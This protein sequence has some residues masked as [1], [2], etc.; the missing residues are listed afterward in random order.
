[1]KLHVPVNQENF[2]FKTSD[3]VANEIVR[4]SE[5]VKKK[6]KSSTLV[7]PFI[8]DLHLGLM[9][10]NLKNLKK[11]SYEHV[12]NLVNV[13]HLI[14]HDLIIQNGDL[15]DGSS[16]ELSDFWEGNEIYKRKMA[17]I[18][19]PVIN[20]RGNHDDNSLADKYENNDLKKVAAYSEL[21]NFFFDDYFTKGK[22]NAD[23]SDKQYGYMDVKG[24]RII[25]I[26]TFDSQQVL[27]NGKNRFDLVDS[28]G[29]IQQTQVNWLINLLKNTSSTQRVLFVSHTAPM[30]VYSDTEKAINTDVL[31]VIIK[32]FVTGGAYDYLGVSNDFPIKI[33]GS[34][35]SK[36]SV[37]A[38][39]HGHRHKD[40]S[41]FI[42]GTSVQCI[43]LLCSKAE[44]NE[45]YIYRNFGTIYEDSFSVL[46]IDEGSIKILRFGA[47]GDIND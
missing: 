44:A 18:S 22:I 13:C 15:N 10:K 11:A 27:L 43:G 24:T 17:S 12:E 41:T 42:K 47:G 40:E 39:L 31:S 36:G 3:N 25:F 1:M 33:T 2:I 23:K 4:F 38:Y 37:I 14:D 30:D 26:D 16:L 6:T 45:S 19:T 5:K 20:L 46:L 7:I 9:P 35:A 32:A 8:T 29:C 21:K 28:N 34:F